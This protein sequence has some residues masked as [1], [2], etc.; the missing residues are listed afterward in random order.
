MALSYSAH[1][2]TLLHWARETLVFAVRHGRPPAVDPS[3]FDPALLEHRAVFITL[4]KEDQLRGCIGHLEA[5]QSLVK[6]IADNTLGAALEDPRF[7]AVTTDEV[8]KIRISISILTPPEPM[9][10]NDEADLL[11]QLRPGIDGLIIASGKRRATF[12]PSVWEEL[13]QPREFLMHLKHK[14]GWR[15]DAWPEDLKVWRYE[16][17]YLS[18]S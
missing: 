7:P 10:I 1:K 5:T 18:E 4:T 2:D 11:R 15:S 6:D 12:L 16:T 14:A 9:H 13:H 3:R 8:D 17:I